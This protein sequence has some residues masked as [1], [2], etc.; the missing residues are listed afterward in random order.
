MMYIFGGGREREG[1]NDMQKEPPDVQTGAAA[2][3]HAQS[4]ALLS[5]PCSNAMLMKCC[6]LTQLKD[7]VQ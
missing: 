4:T 7:E 6:G 1:G 3:A 5:I 2:S